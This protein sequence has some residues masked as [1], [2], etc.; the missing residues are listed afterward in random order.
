ME[1][2]PPTAEN[3]KVARAIELTLLRF[4]VQGKVVTMKRGPT[5]TQYGFLPADNVKVASIEAR[6]KDL[7]LRLGV[8][9]VRIT[10]PGGGLPYIAIEVP[11][12]DR[13]YVSFQ[14]VIGSDEWA[15]SSAKIKLA[16]GTDAAGVPLIPDLTRMPHLLIAGCTNAGKSV[17]LN[18]VINSIVTQHTPDT[19]KLILIDPKR[20]E[21]SQYEELPHLARVITDP[22]MAISALRKLIDF[23]DARYEKLVEL[24]ARNLEVYNQRT[25]RHLPYVVCVVD[26]VGDLMARS[27]KEVEEALVI[28]AQKARAVG[29]HI[30][31][32]TQRPSAQIITGDIKANFPCRVALTTASQADSRVIMDK[33]D[34]A[35][36]IG[37]GDGLFLAPWSLKPI[38][39]QGAYLTDDEI[40]DTVDRWKE[41]ADQKEV[42]RIRAAEEAKARKAAEEAAEAQQRS[43]VDALLAQVEEIV[44]QHQANPESEDEDKQ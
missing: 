5:V 27:K 42:D 2:F 32:S 17:L 20:V 28:L 21:F 41:F 23:M 1:P 24:K 18:T 4:S 30:I 3:Q 15:D 26:E 14:D 9:S 29:I 12:T 37:A 35:N 6:A 10:L 13:Q 19:C 7:T 25:T 33:S 40:A 34:A 11:N 22:L 36:L 31:M 43:S 44:Q 39:M 16:L 8:Q 38:R